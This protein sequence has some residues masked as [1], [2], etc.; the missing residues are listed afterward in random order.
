MHQI[1]LR[2][3]YIKLGQALKAAGL[4]GSGVDAKNEI[5]DGY[6]KV[7]G[8]VELQRG[9]KLYDGDMVEYKGEQIK[10]IK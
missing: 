6:V 2:E 1:K 4:V 9:K 8:N 3:D 10:I 5:L 7:N